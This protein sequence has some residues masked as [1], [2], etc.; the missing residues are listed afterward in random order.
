[1]RGMDIWIV[2]NITC[3]T[4]F[5]W[6]II[7]IKITICAERKAKSNKDGRRGKWHIQDLWQF[8]SEDCQSQTEKK[9]ALM[10]SLRHLTLSRSWGRRKQSFYFVACQKKLLFAAIHHFKRIFSA[11][12]PAA[13]LPRS[14][15][16]PSPLLSVTPSGKVGDSRTVPSRKAV[17]RGYG[18]MA[19]L[20]VH[21]WPEHCCST[22]T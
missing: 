10:L 6:Q 7:K 15:P 17:W 4:V 14:P 3:S 13:P 11:G 5:S 16:S 1:M 2:S 21:L 20:I 19:F 9:T 12:T 8:H 18:F 22:S